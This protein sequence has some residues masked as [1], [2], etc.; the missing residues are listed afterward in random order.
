MEMLEEENYDMD[1]GYLDLDE[2]EK[3]VQDPEKGVIPSEHVVL[4]KEAI[5]KTR[6]AKTLGVIPENHKA[7]IHEVI[8]RNRN[9]KW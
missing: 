4:L 6:K 3:V 1:I 5:I 2:L 8:K 9:E 7:K